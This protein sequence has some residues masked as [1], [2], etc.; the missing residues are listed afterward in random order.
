MHLYDATSTTLL[1][2]NPL[3]VPVIG[4]IASDDELVDDSTD[5]CIIP[6]DIRV[7]DDRSFACV[8]GFGHWCYYEI[9]P[10]GI[11]TRDVSPRLSN[12]T[13]KKGWYQA[14]STRQVAIVTG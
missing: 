3:Y 10:L 2:L 13:S 14:Q 7:Y 8:Y 11:N 9:T 5:K 1:D 4:W 6:N 12:R